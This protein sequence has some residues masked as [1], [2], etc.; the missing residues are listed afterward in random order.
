MGRRYLSPSP[1]LLGVVET[2]RVV[3]CQLMRCAVGV[4][5]DCGHTGWWMEGDHIS[6]CA[7]MCEEEEH[8]DCHAD[9]SVSEL[10]LYINL[11]IG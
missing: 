4:Q 5:V 10:N 7:H 3:G 8:C 2:I 11:D 1:S 6:S 9:S